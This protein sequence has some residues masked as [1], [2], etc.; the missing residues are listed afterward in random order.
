MCKL[1]SFILCLF[2]MLGLTKLTH[3]STAL[4]LPYNFILPLMKIDSIMTLKRIQSL[5]REHSNIYIFIHKSQIFVHFSFSK[6]TEI[7]IYRKKII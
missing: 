1:L 4:F 3:W 7:H 2:R 6:D 5:Y